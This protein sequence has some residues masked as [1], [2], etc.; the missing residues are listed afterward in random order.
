MAIVDNKFIE[1]CNTILNEGIS[2]EFSLV[3]PKW[4]DGSP[5]H[6]KKVF[7]YITKYDLQKEFPAL[8]LRPLPFKNCVDEILWIY[9]KK[10]NNVNNL[11]TI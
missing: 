7:G 10:D 5:A 9:Q 8:T 3:R 2:D 1:M 11:I 6:T 4:E